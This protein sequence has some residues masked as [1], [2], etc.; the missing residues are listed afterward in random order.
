MNR[1][2]PVLILAATTVGLT[3]CQTTADAPNFLQQ[4]GSAT[5]AAGLATTPSFKKGELVEL[6]DGTPSWDL[7]LVILE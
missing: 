1:R 5:A 7:D 6:P 3:G 4:R 2:A